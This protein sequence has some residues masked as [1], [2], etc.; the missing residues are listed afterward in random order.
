VL[1]QTIVYT[2]CLI[3]LLQSQKQDVSPA[4]ERAG[5]FASAL[6]GLNGQFA[7]CATSARP[8]IGG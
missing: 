7:E 2:L 8:Y 4:A 5:T 1:I 3:V 6:R